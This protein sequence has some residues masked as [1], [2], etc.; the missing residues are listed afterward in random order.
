MG[1]LLKYIRN[2]CRPLE[3]LLI[4][5][6]LTLNLIWLANRDI[7]EADRVTT[8]AITDVKRMFQFQVKM[9]QS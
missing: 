5:C 2:F 3:M 8:F 9:T 7:C 6:D 1:L 4:D